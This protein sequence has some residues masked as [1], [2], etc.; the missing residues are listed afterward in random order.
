MSILKY[1]S[2]CRNRY[3]NLTLLLLLVMGLA[4]TATD[5]A[6]ISDI[7]SDARERGPASIMLI[8]DVS[9]SN[10]STDNNGER[11]ILLNWF[12]DSVYAVEPQTMIGLMIF[13]S[14]LWFYP[15]DDPLF[16]GM[17]DSGG[18]YIPLLNA[19]SIYT[20]VYT[21]FDYPGT[22][23]ITKTPYSKKG[24]DVLK[25]YLET[26][27]VNAWGIQPKYWPTK[28]VPQLTNITIPFEAAKQALN[29][30]PH[31]KERHFIVFLSDGGGT[32]QGYIEGKDV[33]TTFTVFY[34]P[35]NP[36]DL[37]ELQQMT[38]NI[39]SNG[40]STTNPT[41]NIWDMAMDRDQLLGLLLNS[42]LDRDRIPQLIPVAS[43]TFERRPIF[44][45]H[46][47]KNPVTSYTIQ[48]DDQ[49][50]FAS[51]VA[52]V[53]I[54]DTSFASTFDL[55][56]GKN[57]WRVR[58]DD[59]PWS[60]AGS[61][62]ILDAR[63]PIL[64]PYQSPTLNHKPTLRWHKPSVPPTSAYSIRIDDNED[65]SSPQVTAEAADTL[66]TCTDALPLGRVYWQVKSDLVNSWSEIGFFDIQPD[67]IP[68]IFRFNGKSAT[69]RRPEFKWHT[70]AGATSYTIMIA[71]NSGF[72]NA[73]TMP[74]SDTT[75]TTQVDLALGKWYWK[76]SS[77]RDPD[78]YCAV[79][80]LTIDITAS[81]VSGNL[82]SINSPTIYQTPGTVRI[83]LDNDAVN[84]SSRLEIYSLNGR[85]ISRLNSA[86]NLT[87]E[88]VWDYSKENIPQGMYLL[89]IITNTVGKVYT[90]LLTY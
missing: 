6:M 67:S 41:S 90:V 73:I 53:P 77:S 43:P 13:A 78:L 45:W 55:P 21:L 59:S 63:V 37:Q 11:F 24:I 49:L 56:L 85:L 19:D 38:E 70:V 72:V 23:S 32:D 52:T 28:S 44:T 2:S 51:P 50:S 47:P 12:L 42:T 81:C 22:S 35:Q 25:M 40:Y 80:S 30:S 18:G 82:K 33:P 75:F 86:D 74:L 76:V 88:I 3:R 46:P 34:N 68:Y 64:I 65:F 10:Q 8:L 14:D 27:I 66:H 26:K 29:H 15:A 31:E 20:G 69:S 89:K 9:S 36:T 62:E 79:D 39:K 5:R 58:G 1:S 57:Y 16:N 60:E 7:T 17:A 54:T 61:F 83:L 84:N 48:M 71:S 87:N 4:H